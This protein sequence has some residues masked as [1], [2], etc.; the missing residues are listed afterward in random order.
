MYYGASLLSLAKLG[1]TK[2]YTL[3]GCDKK[4][5]NAFFVRSDLAEDNFT[6]K[7]VKELY[8]PPKWGGNVK[9]YLSPKDKFI[10]V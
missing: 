10:S 1:K 4:G 8:R 6:S 7:T 5:V 9:R 2:G 3:V